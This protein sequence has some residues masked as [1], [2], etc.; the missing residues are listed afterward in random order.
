[1]GPELLNRADASIVAK[2]YHYHLNKSNL[3]SRKSPRRKFQRATLYSFPAQETLVGRSYGSCSPGTDACCQ[4]VNPDVVH[5]ETMVFRMFFRTWFT[6]LCEPY[7]GAEEAYWTPPRHLC[8]SKN[9]YHIYQ[10][11]VNLY[12]SNYQIIRN[13]NL[14]RTATW[15]LL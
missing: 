9:C 6:R 7:R 10:S 13:E 1:M 3:F 14:S 15:S 5:P 12:S 11:N 4:S 2:L 8:E